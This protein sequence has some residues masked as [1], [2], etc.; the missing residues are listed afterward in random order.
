[1]VKISRT[2]SLQCGFGALQSTQRSRRACT[3]NSTVPHLAALPWLRLFNSLQ[4]E[5]WP[6]RSKGSAKPPWH[7]SS[8][9]LTP[10]QPN[11]RQALSLQ[12]VAFQQ[13]PP[14]AGFMHGPVSLGMAVVEVSPPLAW[15]AH[16]QKV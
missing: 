3:S 11:V 5:L 4:A 8:S 10:L 14:L 9:C 15:A 1:M 16:D 12:Q 7:R 2:H 13:P 6:G